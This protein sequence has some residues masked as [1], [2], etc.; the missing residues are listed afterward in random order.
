MMQIVRDIVCSKC[1]SVNEHEHIH[2][3]MTDFS[4]V[5]LI[6]CKLCGHECEQGTVTSWNDN[7]TPTNFKIT[8]WEGNDPEIY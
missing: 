4:I 2:R 6:K 5:M 1:S 8:E 3:Q 7:G